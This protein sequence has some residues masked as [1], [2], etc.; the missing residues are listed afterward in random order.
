MIKEFLE[1][2]VRRLYKNTKVFFYTLGWFYFIS[3]II[4]AMR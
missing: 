4:K 2:S 1:H 3:I